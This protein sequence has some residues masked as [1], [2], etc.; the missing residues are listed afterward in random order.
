MKGVKQFIKRRNGDRAQRTL[1]MT[2]KIRKE[3]EMKEAI[4]EK[5]LK[6]KVQEA[7]DALNEVFENTHITRTSLSGDEVLFYEGEE[8]AFTYVTNQF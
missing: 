4:D 7:V 1:C 8:L 3:K 2:Q 6:E 5:E